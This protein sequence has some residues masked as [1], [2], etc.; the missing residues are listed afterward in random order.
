MTNNKLKCMIKKC[1][2]VCVMC[3]IDADDDDNM[4]IWLNIV[5]KN[6]TMLRSIWQWHCS[7]Q[8]QINMQ[9]NYVYYCG[10]CVT[11]FND[12]GVRMAKEV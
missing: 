5:W 3:L 1:I 8:L 6:C 10:Q 2:C 11:T 9:V 4:I 7:G 12:D